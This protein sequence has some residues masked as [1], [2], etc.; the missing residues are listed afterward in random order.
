M[1]SFQARIRRLTLSLVTLLL[2]TFSVLL[3][4]GLSTLLYRHIDADLLALGTAESQRVEHETG[5]VKALEGQE[6][7]HEAE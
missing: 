1:K 2:L 7:T 6:T 4:A 5:Q 3:Y